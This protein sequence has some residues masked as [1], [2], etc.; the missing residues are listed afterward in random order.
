MLVEN[1]YVTARVSRIVGSMRPGIHPV[2]CRMARNVEYLY[3]SLPHRLPLK[4]FFHG[5]AINVDRVCIVQPPD[6]L[7][8]FANIA[9]SVASTRSRTVQ[10]SF[11]TPA[12][13]AGVERKAL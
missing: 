4:F 12:A 6:N 8:Q 9:H 5:N 13:I 10:K 11:S 1:C 2:R 3:N 7:S